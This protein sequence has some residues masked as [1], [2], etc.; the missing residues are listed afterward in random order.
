M[1]TPV[2]VGPLIKTLG[3]SILVYMVVNQELLATGTGIRG[4]H[5]PLGITILPSR[6]PVDL[7]VTVLVLA[8]RAIIIVNVHGS[9]AL[10]V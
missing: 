6:V 3:N 10:N 5:F 1:G 2:L 4:W 8:Y 7:L 9:G